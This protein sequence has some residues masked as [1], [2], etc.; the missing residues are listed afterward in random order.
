MEIF[1]PAFH[2]FRVQMTESILTIPGYL[3]RNSSISGQI[4]STVGAFGAVYAIRR[5]FASSPLVS[6]PG[7]P[8]PSLLT[9]HLLQ[10][11]SAKGGIDFC[12][13]ITEEYGEVVKL[14]S[15]FGVRNLLLSRA[16]HY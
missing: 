12:H 16:L 7:P 10:L 13:T 15:L 14:K 3:L 9:G 11:T 5:C 6:I 2:C 8:S 4:A 1:I